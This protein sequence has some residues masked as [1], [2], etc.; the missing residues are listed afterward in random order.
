MVSLDMLD[1]LY[2]HGVNHCDLKSQTVLIF[3]DALREAKAELT[4]QS[5]WEYHWLD[6]T[7][8]DFCDQ[9]L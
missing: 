8:A 4:T 3:K 2:D 5:A 6:S 7:V 9:A 1:A